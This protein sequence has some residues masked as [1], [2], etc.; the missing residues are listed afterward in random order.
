MKF[1]IY[2]DGAGQK[3]NL[4]S[5]FLLAMKEN[6]LE[7]ILDKNILEFEMELLQEVAQLA[8]R[9][10]NMRGEE[11][12][13]MTEVAETLKSIRSTWKEQLIQ[14]LSKETECLIENS[15]HYEP[16]STGQHRSLMATEVC[17]VCH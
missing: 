16:S 2:S 5:S 12:P 1:A 15:S 8:K 4:A 14:N 17:Q 10:L 9:C 7:F 11:R 6:G 3:K 13:L